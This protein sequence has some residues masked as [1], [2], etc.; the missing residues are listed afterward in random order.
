MNEEQ[1]QHN[2][3]STNV[4]VEFFQD[5]VNGDTQ[6]YLQGIAENCGLGGMFIATDRPFLVGSVIWLVFHKEGDPTMS[7]PIYV[8]AI[9]RWV[10]TAVQPYGMGVKF[11]EIKGIES[12]EFIKLVTTFSQ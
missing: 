4:S 9:V 8:H 3:I 11:V 10:Q 12:L 1:R 2:R 5:A 7:D 6:R